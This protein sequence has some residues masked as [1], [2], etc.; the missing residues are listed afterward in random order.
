MYEIDL[1]LFKRGGELEKYLPEYVN[2]LPNLKYFQFTNNG[3]FPVDKIVTFL[4]F[5]IK[6]TVSLKLNNFKKRP[7]HSEQVVFKSLKNIMDPALIK[8][9]VAIAY[10]QGMPTYYV[11]KKVQALKKLAWINTDYVNTQYD[12]EIDFESYR[13]MDKIITVSQHTKDSVSQIREEYKA[14]VELILDIVDPKIINN[15]AQEQLDV[16]FSNSVVNIVTVGR[17]VTA[18]SFDM[19]I[20]VARLL[21]KSGYRFKWYGIGEGPERKK[22]QALIDKYKLNDDFILLGKKLNPY[23]YMKNCDLYV[24]TSV[25]EGFGLT[26]IEAKILKRPI[27]C[28][29]FPTA[30]EIINHHV[31]GLIVEQEIKSIYSGIKKYL[32]DVSFKQGIINELS[33]IE[34][35]SSVNQLNRFYQ[36]VQN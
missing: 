33:S 2:I 21:K 35:Y 14:K 10:S 31:D 25:K 26:V 24:Q 32:D 29:N 17:L 12:K 27:V 8:Y 28:T 23:P 4:F 6:T 5:R 36:L 13:E 22:L 7:V 34:P 18:K 16:E 30:K 9:D 19:A 20:E 11:A 1:L 3:G 15:M